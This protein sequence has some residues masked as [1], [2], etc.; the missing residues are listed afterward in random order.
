VRP[1]VTRPHG[2]H[3]SYAASC[4]GGVSGLVAQPAPTSDLCVV[5]RGPRVHGAASAD[6]IDLVEDR[7]G[8]LVNDRGRFRRISGRESRRPARLGAQARQGWRRPG[9]DR[10]KA[11]CKGYRPACAPIRVASPP[12]PAPNNSGV[13]LRRRRSGRGPSA[14]RPARLIARHALTGNGAQRPVC[15]RRCSAACSL[16]LQFLDALSVGDRQLAYCFTVRDL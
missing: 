16:C 1:L 10:I 8:R 9:H 12:R 14:G 4:G 6:V 15:A 7:R 13:T 2:K 3:V 11:V 5:H